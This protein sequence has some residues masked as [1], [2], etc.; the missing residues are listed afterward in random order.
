MEETA[1]TSQLAFRYAIDKMMETLTDR[2]NTVVDGLIRKLYDCF[3]EAERQKIKSS[4]TNIEK[5]EELFTTLKTKDVGVYERCLRALQELNH[6]QL[7]SELEN[8]WKI[9]ARQPSVFSKL[10]G[11]CSCNPSTLLEG[12]Q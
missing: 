9:S 6:A 8:E 11:C 2:L 5:V 7:A 10:I 3:T 4:R 12:I 1:S